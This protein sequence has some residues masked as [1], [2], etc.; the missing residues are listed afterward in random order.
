MPAKCKEWRG[1]QKHQ[2]R[3][4]ADASSSG[5]ARTARSASYLDPMSCKLR[6]DYWSGKLSAR[7]IQK[8]AEAA[9]ASGA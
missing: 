9:M 8:H 4:R 2:A 7:Y 5:G 3:A 6:E 1:G